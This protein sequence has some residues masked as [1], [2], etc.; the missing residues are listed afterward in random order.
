MKRAFTLVELLVTLAIIAV[1]ATLTL[2]ASGKL[3]DIGNKAMCANSLRQLGTATQL[4]LNDHAQ[5]FFAFAENKPEGKLWYFGLE[6]WGSVGGA[7][8]QRVLDQTAA[9]LYPYIRQVGGIEV[10]R[11]FPYASALWKPKFKGASYGY[12]FNLFLSEQKAVSIAEPARTIVF[13]DCAQVN[14]FQAP[15]SA[16]HPMLEEFYMIENWNPTI[17]FR[18]GNVAQML[19]LDGH[20]EGMSLFPGTQDTR[21]PG[22]MIGRISP[23]GST[24]FLQ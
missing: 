7:E 11:A 19:F 9:P 14:T 3:R 15:A 1:L 10:C 17:H 21:M 16:K 20:V 13:G 22:Q 18:H 4:Y 23:V 6:P 12:G 24:Q 8:G 5:T 2:G